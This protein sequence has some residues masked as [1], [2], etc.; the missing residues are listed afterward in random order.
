MIGDGIELKRYDITY[1]DPRQIEIEVTGVQLL[2]LH[3][4]VAGTLGGSP[5][6]LVRQGA[7][8]AGGTGNI[9]PDLV[10]GSPRVLPAK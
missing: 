8:A 4:A 10:W 2:E 7:N 6:D 1:G 3:T 5:A 9:Q